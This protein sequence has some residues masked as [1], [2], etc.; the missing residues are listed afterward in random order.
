[1][2]PPQ[3]FFVFLLRRPS[4]RLGNAAQDLEELDS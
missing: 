4:H 3:V 2:R 1:M